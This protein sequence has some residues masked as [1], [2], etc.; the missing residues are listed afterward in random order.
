[1]NIC[2]YKGLNEMKSL[3]VLRSHRTESVVDTEFL[4]DE[5]LKVVK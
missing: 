2:I 5:F 1:M 4:F 3:D